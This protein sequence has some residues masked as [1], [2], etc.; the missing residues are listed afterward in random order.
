MST[1]EATAVTPRTIKIQ[2]KQYRQFQVRAD[3]AQGGTEGQPRV[4]PLTFSSEQPVLRFS[5][6][7]WDFY[8]EVLGHTA[9]EVDLTRAE[10]R[11]PLLKSHQRLLH[12]GSVTDVTLDEKQKTLGGLA[13]F[14]SIP[15]AQ[16]QETLLREGHLDTVS[17]GYEVL[18]L[19]LVTQPKDGYPTYRASWKPFEVSTEPIPADETVGFGRAQKLMQE[20]SADLDL[21]EVPLTGHETRGAAPAAPPAEPPAESLSPASPASRTAAPET[22]P[23]PIP[24]EGSGSGAPGARAESSD[25]L[26]AGD[27]PSEPT[28]SEGERDMTNNTPPA[29]G[30]ETSAGAGAGSGGGAAAAV[31]EEPT[32]E[33]RDRGADAAEIMEMAQEHGVSERAAAWVRQGLTPDQ[34]GREILKLQR[35]NP[36]AQPSAESLAGMPDKDKRR[37]SFLRALRMQTEVM[38]GKRGR[39][40]GVEA[41]VHQELEQHRTTADH[42]GILVPWQFRNRE[43]DV[44]GKRTMGTGEAAGGATLVGTQVMPDMI[45]LLRNRALVLQA[46]A[47]LYTGLKGVVYFNKKTGAPT[48]YWMGENPSTG[49][50]GSEPA[51]GYVSMS[52]KTLIGQVQV[53]RQ[54]LVMSDID[55]EQ[56]VMND[57][58]IGHG[59]AYDLGSLHGKGTDK[60]PVGIYNAAGVLSHAVGGIPNLADITTMPAL[61]ADQNADLGNQS[62]MT[63]PL[64]AGVLKRT[65]YESGYPEYLWKGT[66]REG[67]L[68]GYPARSTNQISKTL[69][70]GLNE[71]GLIFGNWEDLML[72][73]WGN[74][75]ELVV[76]VVT[77]ADKGQVKI[78]SYS[79]G[80]S[81]VRRGPSFCKGTGATIA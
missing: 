3:E 53:P 8:W 63:T 5:W 28:P 7:T 73:Q 77:L 15:L 23:P 43:G 39:Y 13:A 9:D 59:L 32:I 71:H 57:L 17:V 45:D 79:M 34:V 14:S 55:M 12:V 33:V 69:G 80:D 54:L 60:E 44:P 66:L 10:R 40:D 56:E 48:V 49:V 22:P 37:Y 21:V 35:T 78:T 41:E 1:T 16:E 65:S 11:L 36:A 81:A 50:T 2:R 24:G 64:M 38:D 68:D 58:A 62:W 20:R 4:Y 31:R 27:P 19:D 47:K 70:A 76:D 51:F 75:L 42:G 18:S 67:T 52:P 26:P 29:Q 72:G 6:E 30:K 74:D 46:G 61:V 25:T